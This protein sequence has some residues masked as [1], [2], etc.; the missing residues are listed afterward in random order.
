MSSREGKNAYRS[1]LF[2]RHPKGM[3]NIP[4]FTLCN[5]W[6]IATGM[7]SPVRCKPA[8]DGKTTLLVNYKVST[9]NSNL[10]NSTYYLKTTTVTNIGMQNKYDPNSNNVVVAVSV[11]EKNVDDTEKESIVQKK[12]NVY[13]VKSDKWR[14][15]DIKWK[16][17]NVEKSIFDSNL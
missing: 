16:A 17:L 13:M 12:Y 4:L 11:I 2:H 15:E 3:E 10:N 6:F 1:I 9:I 8:Y 7:I 14:V 5:R